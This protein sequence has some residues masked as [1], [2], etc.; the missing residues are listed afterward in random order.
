M[1]LISDDERKELAMKLLYFYHRVLIDI[2][3]WIGK[4]RVDVA[5]MA[6]SYFEPF[7]IDFSINCSTTEEK[8]SLYQHIKQFINAVEEFAGEQLI[9]Y[10]DIFDLTHEE[11]QKKYLASYYTMK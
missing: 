10:H 4:K 8:E 5:M 7:Y 11:F 6:A 1:G 2:P 9:R 3:H